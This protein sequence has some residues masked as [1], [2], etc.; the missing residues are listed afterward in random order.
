MESISYIKASPDSTLALTL[1]PHRQDVLALL[2]GTLNP[3]CCY[4]FPV[5][6]TL[7]WHLRQ[8]TFV[9][10]HYLSIIYHCKISIEEN[11]Q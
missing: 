5:N 2:L 11:K 1:V 6:R 7:F 9:V 8:T 4:R 3:L 10:I